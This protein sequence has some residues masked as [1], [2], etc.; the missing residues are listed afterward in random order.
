MRLFS[1]AC[2]ANVKDGCGGLAVAMAFYSGE[3]V[4]TGFLSAAAKLT[5]E[6]C[7]DGNDWFCPYTRGL[8]QRVQRAPNK[9][10]LSCP[11]PE[12][13]S[14]LVARAGLALATSGANPRWDLAQQVLRRIEQAPAGCRYVPEERVGAPDVESGIESQQMV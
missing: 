2:L 10:W 12:M 8:K 5:Q 1:T 9:S 3:P 7:S 11:L 13:R 6:I 4:S 14:L